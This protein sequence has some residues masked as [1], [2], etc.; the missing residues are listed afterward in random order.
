MSIEK[1]CFIP[2]SVRYIIGDYINLLEYDLS[3][4]SLNIIKEVFE[5]F[6]L[7][8]N[9]PKIQEKFSEVCDN[10]QLEISK[11]IYTNHKI[12]SRKM[13]ETFKKACINNQSKIVQWLSKVFYF[14]SHTLDDKKYIFQ[15]VCDNENLEI[16]KLAYNKLGLKDILSGILGE[17][18]IFFD[19][20]CNNK[21]EIAK[22][23]YN[24]FYS[25]RSL[26]YEVI[27][28]YLPYA[29]KYGNLKTAKWLVKEYNIKCVNDRIFVQSCCN[30]QLEIVKWLYY[31]FDFTDID[32]FEIFKNVCNYGYLDI[33]IFL[34]RNYKK[35]ISRSDVINEIFNNVLYESLNVAKWLFETFEPTKDD[36]YTD[37]FRD[38]CE[39]ERIDVAKWLIEVFDLT[40]EELHI[41]DLKVFEYLEKKSETELY[42][43]LKTKYDFSHEKILSRYKEKTK[44]SSQIELFPN[45]IRNIIGSY[46]SILEYNLSD[47]HFHIVEYIGILFDPFFDKEKLMSVLI[48]SCVNGDFNIVKLFYSY[49][50]LNVNILFYKA[51]V[52]NHLKLVKWL[53][54][55]AKDDLKYYSKVFSLTCE[56]NHINVAK[57]LY[58]NIPNLTINASTFTKT[59]VVGH[60]ETAK[61]LAET[62]SIICET[63]SSYIIIFGETCENGHLETAKWIKE[64]NTKFKIDEK[65]SII[66]FDETCRNGHLEVIKWLY[67]NY[68]YDKSNLKESLTDVYS[69]EVVKLF[70]EIFCD[71]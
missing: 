13:C 4:L 54:C 43:L 1:S 18:I 65:R 50:H 62:F 10:N 17:E 11:W 39:Y 47:Q 27:T 55:D 40:E 9:T 44:K 57:W 3:D 31:S 8:I 60:L 38:L 21:V 42:Q 22:F 7:N 5:Y 25:I 20:C 67:E 52:N 51:C 32:A 34:Y 33:A 64:N 30:D 36:L 48:K 29:C 63:K 2:E 37:V 53:Y 71:H 49:N 59:C 23:L 15:K 69:S 6:K 45:S 70:E 58:K 14:N 12:D 19:A 46:I 56:H 41:D 61:W 68:Q 16:I 26:N 24:K 35:I 66:I 28:E